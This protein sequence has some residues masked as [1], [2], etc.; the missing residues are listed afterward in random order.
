[1]IFNAPAIVTTPRP[2]ASHCS[3]HSTVCTM[4]AGED[5]D[6]AGNSCMP[7]V[8][9]ANQQQAAFTGGVGETGE[10][11][12]GEQVWVDTSSIS[13]DSEEGGALSSAASSD[14][15]QALVQLPKHAKKKRSYGS[16]NLAQMEEYVPQEWW[17]DLFN[18]KL[19]LKTD[20]D[21]VEDAGITMLEVDM[22]LEFLKINNDQKAELRNLD[23]CC[24]QGRHTLELARRGFL[25]L[26][27]VDQSPFLINLACQRAAE[28]GYGASDVQFRLGDCK[29]I[30]FPDQSFDT[31]IMAGNSFGYSSNQ[32]DD[33]RVLTE[34]NRVLRTDGMLLLD[35]ADGAWIRGH[36]DP[37]SWEWID[38]E[39]FV[40]RERVLSEDQ[41][42]LIS[43]EVITHVSEGVIKDQFYAE[44]LYSAE[45]ITRILV[46][47]GFHNIE[48]H[49]DWTP[50]SKRQQD[51]GM[52]QHR[53]VVTAA[54][55]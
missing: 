26:K 35:I 16:I 29:F 46:K 34:I 44:R 25:N 3:S 54:R 2:T 30:P 22:F 8:G 45:D 50:D 24:G 27:G 15:D 48:V 53:M 40:C 39:M 7:V 51:L 20:G 49:S 28:H 43:R 21:V 10:G 17:S 32:G 14:S 4:N 36:Y 11:K 52:M 33:I 55:N 41:T 38:K 47:T 42:R 19:Y 12:G 13:S 31:V 37:R 18:D 1:M 6:P 5:D 23:L 9:I